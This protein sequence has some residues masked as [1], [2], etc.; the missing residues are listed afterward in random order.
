MNNQCTSSL[1]LCHGGRTRFWFDFISRKARY[2]TLWDKLLQTRGCVD[3]TRG[4]DPSS[5][6]IILRNWFAFFQRQSSLLL[7]LWSCYF[8]LM[9]F[10]LAT[11][12][13]LVS[14]GVHPPKAMMHFPPVLDFPLFPHI[15]QSPW[16]IFLIF[17]CSKKILAFL[18]I[19][20]TFLTS[21]Y[22]LGIYTIQPYF[23][24]TSF[25]YC[26]FSPYFHSTYVSFA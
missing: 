12:K 24:K 26:T 6:C 21:P 3:A 10:S 17:S 23:G 7:M 15:F 1:H 11:G 19:D 25:P 4:R 20:P 5:V 14:R 22:F 2:K 9:I 13:S 8:I 16:N 18:V